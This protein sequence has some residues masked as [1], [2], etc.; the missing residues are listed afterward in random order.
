MKKVFFEPY[1]EKIIPLSPKESEK[2][3]LKRFEELIEKRE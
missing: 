1:S 2:K 3:F